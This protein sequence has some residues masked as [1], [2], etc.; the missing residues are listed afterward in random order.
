MGVVG[1]LFH[2]GKMFLKTGSKICEVM[3]NSGLSSTFKIEAEKI[4]AK[5][6]WKSIDG[7]CKGDVHDIGKIL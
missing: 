3:K 7:D 4:L 5:A 6:K 1:D 2:N